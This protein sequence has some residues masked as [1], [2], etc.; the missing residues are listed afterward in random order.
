MLFNSCIF[1]LLFLPACIG[2]YFF[3]NRLNYD[4]AALVFLLGMSLWF[5]GYFNVRYL[6]IILSSIIVNYIVSVILGR[7][8][9]GKL[10]KTVFWA[11]VAFNIGLLFYF[12]YYD[13]CM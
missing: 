13:F 2:G 12:K 4:K 7:Q 10:R 11:P 6:F 1:I 5:Y 3:L 9:E 8:K